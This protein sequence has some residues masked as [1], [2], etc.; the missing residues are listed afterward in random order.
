[1]KKIFAL[2]LALLLVLGL[3]ACD[4]DDAPAPTPST[5]TNA[6]QNDAPTPDPASSDTA[7]ADSYTLSQ[8]AD[9]ISKAAA[10]QIALE[11][12]GVTEAQIS[13]YKLE[14]DTQK[15]LP[16]YE[17]EFNVGTD[18]YDYD[19][20]VQTGKILDAE[21]NDK[22]LLAEAYKKIAESEAKAVALKHAGLKEAD[23]TNY[24]IEFDVDDGIPSYEIEFCSGGYE[25]EYDIHSSDG[26][27]IKSEKEIID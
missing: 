26:K 2:L 7:P 16:I 21:K 11:H 22:S 27:I 6:S 3:A 12:A 25:Y 9:K 13:A 19:I 15:G 1:M 14:L 23:I 10:K 8:P 24:K 18:Q 17:I 5:Q 20:N 4:A